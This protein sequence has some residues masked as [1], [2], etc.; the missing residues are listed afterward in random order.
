MAFPV[1]PNAFQKRKKTPEE[2]AAENAAR[3]TPPVQTVQAQRPIPLPTSFKGEGGAPSLKTVEGSDG[4]VF[5]DIQR[6]SQGGGVVA[7]NTAERQ[8]AINEQAL[9]F[10]L[11]TQEAGQEL[12][13]IN[14]LA[15]EQRNKEQINRVLLNPLTKKGILSN[16][17]TSGNLGQDISMGATEFISTAAEVYDAM[18]SMV[19]GR[20]TLK[21]QKAEASFTDATAILQQDLEMV[22][23]GQMSA[24][25]ASR[26]LE[27][28]AAAINR[29][30]SSAKGIGKDNLRWFIDQGKEIE[31]QIIREKRILENLRLE[32]I[33]AQQEARVNRAKLNLGIQ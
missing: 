30:E 11:K 9:Q 21:T 1:N 3:Q 25:D 18:V 15:L 13:T 5:L 31:T 23:S 32:L 24:I 14:D 10:Q 29:L 2:I 22:R 4:S 12:P 7:P 17:E 27:E 6:R 26:D 28:A 33:N 8:A 20:K 19:K 16:V